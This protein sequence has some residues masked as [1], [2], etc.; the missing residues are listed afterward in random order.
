MIHLNNDQYNIDKY[1]NKVHLDNCGLLK[2]ANNDDLI[3]IGR[4]NASLLLKIHFC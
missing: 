2:V 1:E 4:D 3:E